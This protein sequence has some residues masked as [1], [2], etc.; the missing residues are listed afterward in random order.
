M[1]SDVPKPTPSIDLTP[2]Q[3]LLSSGS[4]KGMYTYFLLA[5]CRNYFETAKTSDSTGSDIERATVALISFCP[6]RQR[7]EELWDY[8]LDQKKDVNTFSASVH[9]V[10]EL[11]SYLS[12][13]LEFEEYSTGGLL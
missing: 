12:E 8:Y 1:E 6:N 11:I 4:P 2:T 10:G 9:V 3:S 7:R 5:L 13:L